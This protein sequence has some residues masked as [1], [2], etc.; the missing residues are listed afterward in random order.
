VTVKH[1]TTMHQKY[2]S[3]KPNRISGLGLIRNS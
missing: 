1:P 2:A 3:E